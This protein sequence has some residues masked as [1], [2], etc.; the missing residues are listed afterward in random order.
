VKSLLSFGR[1]GAALLSLL[2][3]ASLQA[4][5]FADRY[6]QVR[7]FFPQADRFGELEGE[8]PSAA[9]H[10]GTQLLGYVFLTADVVQ[11]P[12]YSGRPINTLVA[13]D[14][15]G[16]IV[17]IQIVQHEEPILVVGITEA[18]LAHFVGQYRGKSVYDKVAVGAERAGHVRIDAIS[19]ATITVMVENAT[20]MQAVRRVA[21]ARG[22]TPERVAAAAVGAAPLAPMEVLPAIAA[23]GAQAVRTPAPAAGLRPEAKP[24]AGARGPLPV[25]AEPEYEPV[26]AI[27]WRERVIEIALLVAGLVFLT[28]VLVFQ[29]W[30]A[31]HPTLLRKL[32]NGFLVYTLVF[33]GWY[34]LA[35]LSVVNVLTFVHSIMHG[36]QWQSFL[37]E[38]LMFILWSFVAVTLLLWGRGVYCGW[39]CPFGALQELSFQIGQRFG[40]RA[41]EMPQMLHERLWALKYIILLGLF[42]LSLQ[43]LTLA[44]QVSEVEPFKTAITLRFM[45]EW[46]FVAY[47]GG[48]VV[49]GLFNRKFFCKYLC[50]LGAA[51][52]IAGKFRIF[53]WLRRHRE[54][55]RPCQICAVECEVQA[56]KKNGEI[57]A[58]ECHYC[59]DCQ[60]TYWNDHKCPPMVD[61][62]KRREKSGRA[63]ELVRGMESTLGRS[64]LEDIPIK[65][66]PRPRDPSAA[67]PG[68]R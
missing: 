43:S 24:Q 56:I 40:V 55:G 63:R 65:V 9:I 17:G 11:I 18:R 33:I 38:P 12:A 5:D 51:L 37:I 35:Q 26:W 14:V 57:N 10:R 2:F 62:R 67:G 61:R 47:A 27:L 48:L 16:R 3:A 29:D 1:V 64:G 19:G 13:F 59:L 8:P 6:P 4:A 54:C 21:Q 50:A 60:V 49:L 58:N 66:E 36:F 45:R 15:A 23:P 39:L 52:T 53:D 7:G 68:K 44:Q 20:V 30:L 34:A 25:T 32:R 41:F 42:G 31:R 46:G 28:L 22:L